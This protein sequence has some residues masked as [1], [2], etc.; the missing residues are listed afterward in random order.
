MDIP[1]DL[2]TRITVA[3]FPKALGAPGVDCLVAIYAPAHEQLGRRYALNTDL[4]TIGRGRDNDIM[5]ASDCVSRQHARIERRGAELYLV[6]LSSTNGTFVNDD[7]SCIREHRMVPGD[8]LKIGDL[9]FKYLSGSDVESQYHEIIF[10]MTVTDGLTNLANRKQ[11]DAVLS[12]EVVRAQRHA[13]PLSLLLIDI[14]HF[15]R[16]NDNYGHLAG[17]AILRALAGLLQKRA[18][19]S[20]KL[21]RYGGEEFCAILPETDL[22]AALAIAEEWRRLV[23]EQLFAAERQQIRLTISLGVSSFRPGMQPDDLYRLA[24]VMLYMAKGSGRNRVGRAGL[25]L[26]NGD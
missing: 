26:V 25:G 2:N 4:V 13:R 14:D 8:Q 21:G 9:I 15:K 19:Q 24:D 5:L 11:L 10:G 12:E 16:I 6:D 20:D 3:A 17:D 7:Q 23:A 18:R 1:S 22:Q